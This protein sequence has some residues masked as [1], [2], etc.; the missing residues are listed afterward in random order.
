MTK[1]KLTSQAPVLFVSDIDA[2]ILYWTE[3]IGFSAQKFGEPTNFCILHRDNC[4]LMISQKPKDHVIVPNWRVQDMIW[5]CYIWVDDAK[6]LY[7]ELVKSGAGI[8]YHLGQKDYGVLEFGIS[9]L[10]DH[11]IAF[12]QVLS[13]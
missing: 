9:D 8:D 13:N 2:S 10:D 11:D 12:G 4:H 5:G 6:K 1:A 3:K 7:D